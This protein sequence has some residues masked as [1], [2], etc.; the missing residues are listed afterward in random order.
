MQQNLCN[1]VICEWKL[2]LGPDDVSDT[3]KYVF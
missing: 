2:K 1:D 3:M